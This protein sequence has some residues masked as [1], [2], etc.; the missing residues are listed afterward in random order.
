MER[1]DVMGWVAAYERAWREDD[2]G[3]LGTLF[4][5]GVRYLRS[6]YEPALEG[7]AAV[8]DFWP[9]PTPFTLDA[10]VVA[11]EGADAVVRAEV[12][13]GGD[14][15]QEYRDLWVLRFAADGRVEHFEEWAYWPGKSFTASDG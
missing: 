3:S 10:Q 6:P 7:L 11:V 8:Q 15:P 13:Y 9:D 2:A 5:D 4:T 14:E 12:R 1:A